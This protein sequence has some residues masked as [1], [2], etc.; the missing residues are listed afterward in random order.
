MKRI[1][2]LISRYLLQAILPYLI[3][4]WL[5][6]SVILFAQQASRFADIFFSVNIPS[7][8]IWQLTLALIPNVI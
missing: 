7:N 5:L 6:L 8:L 2:L 3:F 4:S 1:S